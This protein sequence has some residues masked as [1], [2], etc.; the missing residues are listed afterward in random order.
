MGFPY[1]LSV[2]LLLHVMKTSLNYLFCTC[3]PEVINFNNCSVFLRARLDVVDCS[4]F[5]F[6]CHSVGIFVNIKAVK[7][8]KNCAYW[9]FIGLKNTIK[10]TSLKVLSVKFAFTAHIFR[11]EKY[12]LLAIS[13]IIILFKKNI[14]KHKTRIEFIFSVLISICMRL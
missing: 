10:G 2:L 1:F 13:D 14:F 4:L 8:G 5:F 12:L 9:A 7:Y 6:F 11:S 3:V